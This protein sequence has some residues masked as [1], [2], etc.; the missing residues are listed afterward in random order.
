MAARR[1]I[2][3]TQS[4]PASAVPDVPP[5]QNPFERLPKRVACPQCGT[6]VVLPT[7]GG[8]VCPRCGYGADPAKPQES[9]MDTAGPWYACGLG[10]A[11][12]ATNA[13][14]FFFLVA[15]TYAAGL[16]I[17]V[18]LF[19]ILLGMSQ[20]SST[21]S[22]C[23]CESSGGGTCC[24]CGCGGC[25]DGCCGDCGCGDCG[26]GDCGCGGCGG[27]SCTTVGQSLATAAAMGPTLVLAE[28]SAGR[29]AHHPDLPA[30]EQDTYRIAGAR[31]CIGC[32]TTYPLFLA[33]STW[34]AL[35]GLGGPWWLGL[36]VGLP[37]AATQAASAA[38]WTTRKA[39]KIAVKACL[40]LG[41]ALAVHAILQAPW[42]H[43]LQ[44]VA[45]GA[46]LGLGALSA[47]PR[48]RRI[49]RALAT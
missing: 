26:C 45:L 35:G 7:Q 42:P 41:L 32:F 24:D 43:L 27:C 17:V 11:L 22:G 21:S 39:L 48:R 3:R 31:F 5:E 14:L 19:L 13:A 16:A 10:G 15:I 29:F 49:A 44:A 46:L 20:A 47:L 6:H 37:L 12:L 25:C 4:R 2:R 18:F 30:F 40:G 8:P 28:A 33:A 23:T 36:A 9:W 34:L 1:V 38:G